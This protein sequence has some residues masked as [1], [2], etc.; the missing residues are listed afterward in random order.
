VR[1]LRSTV[2]GLPADAHAQLPPSAS[3]WGCCCTGVSRSRAPGNA[4]GIGRNEGGGLGGREKLQRRRQ[5][6]ARGRPFAISRRLWPLEPRGPAVLDPTR[7]SRIEIGDQAGARTVA[8][9]V[10]PC[11]VS[12]QTCRLPPRRTVGRRCSLEGVARAEPTLETQRRLRYEIK[13]I[14]LPADRLCP[15]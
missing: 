2:R 6:Q 5:R 4:V 13:P 10:R 14:N 9:P 12:G 3:A 11:S 7:H 1:R 15:M 8:C